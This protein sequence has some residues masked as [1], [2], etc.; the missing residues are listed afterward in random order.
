MLVLRER[1]SL[2]KEFGEIVMKLVGMVVKL[3]VVVMVLVVLML[4]FMV[5]VGFGNEVWML[6]ILIEVWLR[7]MCSSDFVC[8]F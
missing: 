4:I 8:M 7:M 3:C 6:G 5:F 1:F 2:L